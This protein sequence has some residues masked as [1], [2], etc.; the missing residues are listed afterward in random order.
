MSILLLS[1]EYSFTAVRPYYM[2]HCYVNDIT[3]LP[4]TRRVIRI[5]LVKIDSTLTETV[6]IIFLLTN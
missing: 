3:Y 2:A 1:Y 4:G 5:R 6:G